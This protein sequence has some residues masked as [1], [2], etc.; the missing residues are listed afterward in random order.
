MMKDIISK[1]LFEQFEHCRK[2]GCNVLDI[3]SIIDYAL[4]NKLF[5]LESISKNTLSLMVR[6]YMRYKNK[7]VYGK[8]K[9][10]KGEN[11]DT[12]IIA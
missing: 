3:N 8:I 2:A 7:Y 1:K 6:D 4:A 9:N 5:E 12:G 10:K 11:N